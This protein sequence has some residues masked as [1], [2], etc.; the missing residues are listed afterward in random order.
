M[1]SWLREGEVWGDDRE[2]S[3]EERPKDGGH[4]NSGQDDPDESKVEYVG[5][6]G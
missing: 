2:G 6:E 4:L 5:E 3:S 1:E